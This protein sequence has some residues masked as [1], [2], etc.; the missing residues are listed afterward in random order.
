MRNFA[1]FIYGLSELDAADLSLE[2]VRMN[3][4]RAINKIA[5]QARTKAADKMR[6]QVNFP[7][8]YLSPAGGRLIVSRLARRDSL[9]STISARGRPTSLARFV[10]GYTPGKKGVTV[11]VQSGKSVTMPEAFIV[12]LPA[13]RNIETKS[14]MGLAVRLKPGTKL[15]NKTNAVRLDS[16][17][18]L[19]YGPSVDQVFLNATGAKAGEGVATD[20]RYQDDILDDLEREFLR[21]MERDNAS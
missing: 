19:L 12:K 15:R 3:A 16:G 18:Y 4:V 8:G 2:N 7:N 9:E 1:V 21:L 14:N 17:L 10:T 5:P 20:P 6:T 13:G 11:S